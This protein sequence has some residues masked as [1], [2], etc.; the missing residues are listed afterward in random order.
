[1]SFQGGLGLCARMRLAFFTDTHL[2]HEHALRSRDGRRRSDDFM[3]SFQ[4]VLDHVRQNRIPLLLH[5]GDLFFRSK[6]GPALVDDAYARLVQLAEEGVTIGLI[7]G[8]H[9]RSALPA[10]LLL[11]HPRIHLF[12]Q[13]GAH[14]FHVDGGTI[15]VTGVPFVGHGVRAGLPGLLAGMAGAAADARVLLLHEAVD[16]ATCGPAG[17]T[18]HGRDDVV[19][20]ESVEAG[21][22]VVLCGHIHRRQ[23]LQGRGAPVVY[24]GST[25]RTSFAEAAEV[26]AFAEIDLDGN[27]HGRVR[28]IPLAARPMAQLDQGGP[29]LEADVAEAV[30]QAPPDALLRITCDQDALPRMAQVAHQLAPPSMMLSFRPR[31]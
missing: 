31:R 7:A 13:P 27:G 12:H 14:V 19:A 16:G 11:R 21:V 10:S 22:D 20:R 29:V 26:K 30:S 6:L 4:R 25:E 28:F 8:N 23:V 24:A 2:G 17:F 18:F 9:D 15:S 5:G 3:D 1:M